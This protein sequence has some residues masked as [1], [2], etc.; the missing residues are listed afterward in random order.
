V[1]YCMQFLV[2]RLWR[3]SAAAAAASAAAAQGAPAHGHA[4]PD[5]EER[6]GALVRGL[7][8]AEARRRHEEEEVATGDFVGAGTTLLCAQAPQA[9]AQ[10]QAEELRLKAALAAELRKSAERL[11][12]EVQRCSGGVGDS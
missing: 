3:V 7:E 8:A 12:V 5:M 11:E 2:V 4:A 10:A 1:N 6:V 9:Q